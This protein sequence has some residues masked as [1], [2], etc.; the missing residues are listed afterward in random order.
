M[1]DIGYSPHT[2]LQ[3]VGNGFEGLSLPSPFKNLGNVVLAQLGKWTC[4]SA[5]SLRPSFTRN[6]LTHIG[7]GGCTMNVDGIAARREIAPMSGLMFRWHRALMEGFPQHTCS[8]AQFRPCGF[9]CDNGSVAIA[10][11][12]SLP[13]KAAV[14]TVLPVHANLNVVPQ[15]LFQRQARAFIGTIF[16]LS[17]FIQ[18]SKRLTTEDI[19]TGLFQTLLKLSCVSTTWRTIAPCRLMFSLRSQPSEHDRAGRILAGPFFP[20]AR[21]LHSFGSKVARA[22]A[23]F[24]ALGHFPLG[25]GKDSSTRRVFTHALDVRLHALKRLYGIV[26]GLRA[27]F[28]TTCFKLGWGN[29][30][31]TTTRRILADTTYWHETQPP[32]VEKRS[33]Y[34]ARPSVEAGFSGG[35]DSALAATQSITYR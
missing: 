28:A 9:S 10:I 15:P 24:D 2:Y 22:G 26:T 4:F 35:H 19:L 21:V 12:G 18:H 30:K 14:N 25:G 6:S 13:R 1:Q 3:G 7:A 20:P 8:I 11:P 16:P 5:P 23:I 31:K 27:V 17:L 32:L 29:S 34:R 33:T